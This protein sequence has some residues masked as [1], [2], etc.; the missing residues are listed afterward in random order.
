MSPFS[1]LPYRPEQV[2]DLSDAEAEAY[3]GWLRIE[4]IIA[5]RSKDQ[6]SATEVRLRSE[7]A[8]ATARRQTA[9]DRARELATASEHLLASLASRNRS[10][11]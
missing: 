5:E 4:S 9:M 6:A 7:L 1:S 10:R 2:K 11:T 8:D 3:A